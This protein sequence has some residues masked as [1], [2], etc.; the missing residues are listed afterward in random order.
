MK[1]FTHHALILGG[2]YFVVSLLFSWAN[3]NF[4][5]VDVAAFVMFFAL[6]I[7]LCFKRKYN[8]LLCFQN[9][10][11]KTGNYIKALGIAQY[12]KI[13]FM[14]FP[15]IVYG[16]RASK[17]QYFGWEIPLPPIMYMQIVSYIYW[18]V[19]LLSLIWATYQSFGK[20]KPNEAI[21]AGRK[22]P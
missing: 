10:Y 3:G 9:K 5:M 7:V 2:L 4:G 15:G 6:F 8:F 22:N 21:A 11:I 19:L 12:Y 13:I 14:F 16:Y 17:A 1:S 18:G 20:Q